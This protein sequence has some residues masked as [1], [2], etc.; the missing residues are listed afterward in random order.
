M[1]SVS[2]YYSATEA[3]N[4][5]TRQINNGWRVVACTMG[6]Y[7]AGYTVGERVLVVYEK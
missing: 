7:E 2:L 3:Y 5:M 6:C 4:A 1:Q